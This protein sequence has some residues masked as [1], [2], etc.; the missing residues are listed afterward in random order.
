MLKSILIEN[1]QLRI[2]EFKINM[3][4]WEIKLTL[5]ESKQKLK[6][7]RLMIHMELD[8]LDL[9]LLIINLM[10]ELKCL[11]FRRLGLNLKRRRTKLIQMFDTWLGRMSL[12]FPRHLTLLLQQCQHDLLKRILKELMMLI[13]KNQSMKMINQNPQNPQRKQSYR[14]QKV[15]RNSSN[16]LH[17]TMNKKQDR[18][19][20]LNDNQHLQ[21][22]WW[23][24]NQ[25]STQ[26]HSLKLHQ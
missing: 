26:T 17:N 12:Q 20:Q 24:P 14:T 6:C 8:K 5:R 22:Q 19:P 18:N 21:L 1:S 10:W 11:S 2:K 23:Q 15:S 13:L 4:N 7:W 16:S 3:K 25:N 9:M